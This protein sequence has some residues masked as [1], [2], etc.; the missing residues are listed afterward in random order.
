L[1]QPWLC[2]HSFLRK[3]LEWEVVVV[4]IIFNFCD[5]FVTSERAY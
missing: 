3:L 5:L 4:V 2:L 1:T